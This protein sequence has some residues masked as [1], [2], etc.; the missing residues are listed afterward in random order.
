MGLAEVGLAGWGMLELRVRAVET[1]EQALVTLDAEDVCAVIT[2]L[3]LASRSY[4]PH[5]IARDGFD[6]IA[7]LRSTP[8][9]AS[10]PVI[11]TSGDT[12]PGTAA[13]LASLGVEDY[14]PKPYS[15]GAVRNRLEQL[16]RKSQSADP[17][18]VDN[19]IATETESTGG[20]P[21]A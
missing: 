3:H 8:R 1:A 4:S 9:Y 21:S 5:A 20:L 12:D 13:R 10:L 16:I 2:D 18:A 14:F 17:H 7:A 15:P 11:V 6:L 19:Q